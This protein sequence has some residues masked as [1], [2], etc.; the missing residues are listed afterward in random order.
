MDMNPRKII[1]EAR[2]AVT[3]KTYATAQSTIRIIS[4]YFT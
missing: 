1:N 2:D 3:N 4:K